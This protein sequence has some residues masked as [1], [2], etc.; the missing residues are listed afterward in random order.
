MSKKDDK[1]DKGKDD[2]PE[3][4]ENKNGRTKS[5]NMRVVLN[6]WFIQKVQNMA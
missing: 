5:A 2:A 4:E 3:T 6:S 1:S